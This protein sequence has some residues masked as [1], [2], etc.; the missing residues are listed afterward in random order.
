[1]EMEGREQSLRK[2]VRQQMLD[3][4]EK[5]DFSFSTRLLSENQM[6]AKFQV[7]RSTIRA[8]LTELEAEGKSFGGTAAELMS[9]RPRCTLPLP[10]TPE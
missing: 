5:M 8:V 1:M 2:R 7:S 6:A 10:F 3:L 9:I 4:M